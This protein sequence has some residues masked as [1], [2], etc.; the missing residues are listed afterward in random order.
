[1]VLPVCRSRLRVQLGPDVSVSISL[2]GGGRK[3]GRVFRGGFTCRRMQ[4]KRLARTP[5]RA[6]VRRKE[7][8]DCISSVGGSGASPQSPAGLVHNF[9]RAS[10][11]RSTRRSEMW[12]CFPRAAT[13][14]TV[15]GSCTRY[16]SRLG[17]HGS[18]GLRNPGDCHCWKWRRMI[19][20]NLV[21]SIMWKFVQPETVNFRP[22]DLR[23]ISVGAKRASSREWRCGSARVRVVWAPGSAP[24]SRAWPRGRGRRN[25]S[26][27]GTFPMSTSPPISG[28]R[29]IAIAG[30]GD[31]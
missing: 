27:G 18:T 12:S 19:W 11:Y 22:Y 29:V 5:P 25:G 14:S 31:G 9:C 1:M 20:N 28:I 3:C 13:C 26:C 15:N 16:R 8:G 21:V 10:R 17:V 4:S 24:H 6:P 30:S 7:R 2:D 23:G